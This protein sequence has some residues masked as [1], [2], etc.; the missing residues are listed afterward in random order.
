VHIHTLLL[1]GSSPVEERDFLYAPQAEFHGEAG[2]L[3]TA[4]GIS[5]AGKSPDTVQT[6]F[7]RGGFFLTHV[8]EC[9][10][11]QENAGTA[12]VSS[13]LA[14]HLPKATARIRRSL[15]PKRVMVVTEL[16]DGIV[17]S[18]LLAEFGCPVV[19]DDGKPFHLDGGSAKNGLARLREALA[20]RAGD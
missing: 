20:A 18:I 19:M 11:E 2:L 1:G 7:Q 12:M 10:L 8:L 4:A 6:E 15:K 16:L 5:T 17:D 9:P 3:V 13:L 14:E